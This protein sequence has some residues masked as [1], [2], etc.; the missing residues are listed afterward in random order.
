[1]SDS[2]HESAEEEVK[3]GPLT[4]DTA[5]EQVIQKAQVHDGLVHGLNEV[6][7]ALDRNEAELVLLASDCQEDK[8]KK[9]VSAFA[10]QNKTPLIE[11]PKRVT[12]GEWVGYHKRDEE[13]NKR[14]I[15]GVSSVVIKAYGNTDSEAYA[16]VQNHIKSS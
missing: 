5:L 6:V 1:M 13:G 15:K 16:F 3:A 7:K 12:L 4:L 10:E 9:L 2:G 8:Y 14:K 11:I